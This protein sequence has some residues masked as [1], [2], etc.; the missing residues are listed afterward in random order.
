MTPEQVAALQDAVGI[1][2]GTFPDRLAATGP[3]ARA[4]YGALLP[5]FAATGNPPALA[6]A[7][8]AAGLPPDTAG[9]A[10]AELAA[11]DLVALGPA[12]E[13]AGAFPL[14]AIATRHQVRI[15]GRPVLHAMCAVDALGIPAMLHSG[16]VVT[17]ADPATGQ[18]IAVTVSADGGLDVHPSDAVVLLARSGDGPL[19]TACCSIIDFHTDATAARR[20]LETPGAR[21]AVISVADAHALGT[22]LFLGLPANPTSGKREAS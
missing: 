2:A 3:P 5:A 21:G 11:A 9:A 7:A 8:A 12:G 1:A 10:L 19:A 6:D 20:V 15:D 16:G 13:V 18:P 4:L 17:S 14:S 22:A